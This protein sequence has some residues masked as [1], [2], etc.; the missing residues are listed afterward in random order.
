MRTLLVRQ[1]AAENAEGFSIWLRTD[2]A[3]W[4]RPEQF[5]LLVSFCATFAEDLYRAGRLTTVAIDTEPPAPIRRL[6]DLEDFLDQ[7]AVVEPRARATTEAGSDS[8]HPFASATTVARQNVLTFAPDGARGVA[9]YV[10][11]NKAAS[12]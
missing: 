7:L 4:P 9:A 1:F 3:V 6:R 2:A 10:N 12:A 5:E 11:G 8:N